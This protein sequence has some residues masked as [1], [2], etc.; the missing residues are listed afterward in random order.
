MN[1]EMI[2][3]L[4]LWYGIFLL[5]VQV[6]DW[7]ITLGLKSVPRYSTISETFIRMFRASN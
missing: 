3:F 5:L 7:A 2:T 6:Y 1:K 4:D